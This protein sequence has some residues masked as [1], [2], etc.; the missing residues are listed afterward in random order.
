VLR[1]TQDTAIRQVT[2]AYDMVKSA[3]AEYDSALVTASNIAYDSA[4]DSYRRLELLQMQRRP[5]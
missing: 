5:L 1:K 2:K 3:L 4:I